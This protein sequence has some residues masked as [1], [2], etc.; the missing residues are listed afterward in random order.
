[1]ALEG[2]LAHFRLPDILQV[3]SHQRKTG[4]LTV[5]GKSDILAVSFLDGGIVSADALNQSFDGLLGDALAGRGLVPS[6]EF[7]RLLG[8]QRSSG[9]RLIDFLVERKAINREQVLEVLQELT[10]RLIVDVLRWREGQFKFYGGE[11]V[12]FEEGIRPLRVEDLLMRSILDLPANEGRAVGIPHG[13]LTYIKD[14]EARPVRRIPTG[15]DDTTP[16]DPAIAWVTPDE[17]AVLERIDGQSPAETLARLS[18]LG[19]QRTYFALSRLLEA[20]LVREAREDEQVSTLSVA[21]PPAPAPARVD[22][23]EALRIEREV[24]FREELPAAAPRPL[25][26]SATRAIRVLPLLAA[27]GAV[28]AGFVVPAAL[29]FP[30]PGSTSDREAYERLCRVARYGAI[31]RA[32]RTFHL[33]E[34]RY[35]AA[36]DELVLRGLLAADARRDPRGSRFDYRPGQDEYEIVPTLEVGGEASSGTRE[37]VFGDFLLDHALFQGL[38]RESGIPIV[39]ID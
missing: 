14:S 5:Q 12:A 11:E 30:A 21:A 9:V 27:L 31:D 15:F 39:L 2:D 4:I 24:A 20:G 22:R 26:R 23:G 6:V 7:S 35:P 38:E 19:E 16:L 25:G 17:E 33:L 32:A 1:M 36:L 37:G 29:F 13:F 3:I 18:G 8:E 10:Y 28:A 34:G